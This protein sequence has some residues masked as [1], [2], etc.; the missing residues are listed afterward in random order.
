VALDD[1]KSSSYPLSACST[2]FGEL[3]IHVTVQ[4]KEPQSTL[5]QGAL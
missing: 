5:R 4:L 1:Y 3:V 2:A